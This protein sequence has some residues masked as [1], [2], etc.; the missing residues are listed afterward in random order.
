MNPTTYNETT[1]SD[2]NNF[3]D[4]RSEDQNVSLTIKID[5]LQNL[6]IPESNVKKYISSGTWFW[7]QDFIKAMKQQA[8]NLPNYDESTFTSE[9]T[10]AQKNYPPEYL[11]EIY[12]KQYYTDFNN[13]AKQKNIACNIDPSTKKAIGDTMFTID[14][15]GNITDSVVDNSLLP[16]LIP[17]FAFLNEACN[18]CNLMN[19][20]FDCPF[21][22]PDPNNKPLFPGFIMNYAWNSNTT[23]NVTNELTSNLA[24]LF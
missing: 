16:T 22:N 19:K 3:I 8:I 18:P 4:N 1:I 14:L 20:S 10:Q 12:S 9:I 17:G 24:S 13:V 7:P 5:Q 6:G 15:S 11:I 23:E 2:Y 21:T